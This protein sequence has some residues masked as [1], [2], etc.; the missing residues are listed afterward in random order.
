V[1]STSEVDST[2]VLLTFSNQTVRMLTI[3]DNPLVKRDVALLRDVRT[4]PDRFRAAMQRIGTVIAVEAAQ[5]LTLRTT[6]VH[7]PLEETDGYEMAHDVVLLPVLRA[8]V[9]LVEPFSALMPEAKIAYI[10]LIRDEG[11]LST[12]EY[13]YNVP[14]LN[15]NSVVYILDPMLATGGSICATIQRITSVGARNI[16]VVAVIAAPEGVKRVET[17]YPDVPIITAA[18][19]RCLNEHGFIMPGLGDA[20]DRYHGTV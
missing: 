14:T 9:S 12:R 7:T 16:V 19:D 13:Y 18:L 17:A 5:N 8:G 3:L 1:E 4:T 6:R 10:G 15:P 20:G 2:L 11:T